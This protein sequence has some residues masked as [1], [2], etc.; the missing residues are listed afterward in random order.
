M[1]DV[2][3]FHRKPQPKE[4]KESH[5]MSC[6]RE[7]DWLVWR[8]HECSRKAKTNMTTSEMVFER[9]GNF[10]AHHTFQCYRPSQKEWEDADLPPMDLDIDFTFPPKGGT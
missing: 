5:F 4:Y 6:T 9:Q 2:L 10:F 7:D 8:C 1:T 3:D